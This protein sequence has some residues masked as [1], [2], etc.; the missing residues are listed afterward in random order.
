M[1][2][3]PI[4]PRGSA[5]VNIANFN[6]VIHH[7][8]DIELTTRLSTGM[9][10]HRPHLLLHSRFGAGLSKFA[11]LYAICLPESLSL[12]AISAGYA[13]PNYASLWPHCLCTQPVVMLLNLWQSTSFVPSNNDRDYCKKMT[14][15]FI[16]YGVMRAMEPL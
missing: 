9:T 8:S 2:S 13:L 4:H 10:K 11:A 15:K 7:T 6:D 1:A 16:H 14:I 5:P 12:S 3:H